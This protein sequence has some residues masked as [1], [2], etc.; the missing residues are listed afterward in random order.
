MRLLV[1]G[2]RDFVDRDLL[3]Q[4]L[5]RK[6]MEHEDL[7]IVHGD[8]PSG[9]DR[10]ARSWARWEGIPDEPYP[11]DWNKYGKAAGP[12]RNQEMIDSKPDEAWFFPV[13]AAR[14]T[15]DC[16]ERAERAGIPYVIFG[17]FE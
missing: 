9:L 16:F 15:R 1:S 8:C 5:T 11:A 13:G 4:L 12:I 10:L 6:W 2:S 7:I 3:A 17:E 14:G